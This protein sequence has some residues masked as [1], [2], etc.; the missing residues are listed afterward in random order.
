MDAFPAPD[1]ATG[2]Q[3]LLLHHVATIGLQ[4]P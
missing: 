1:G 4:G 3:R 2:L